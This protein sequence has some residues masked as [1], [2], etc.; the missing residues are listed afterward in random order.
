[1]EKGKEIETQDYIWKMG[2]T[3]WE[4]PWLLCEYKCTKES[5]ESLH[6]IVPA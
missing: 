6:V 5:A 2:Q 4:R 1:M 3:Q